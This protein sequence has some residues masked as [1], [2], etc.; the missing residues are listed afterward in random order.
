MI[1]MA[2][3]LMA[4]MQQAPVEL[5]IND[6]CGMIADGKPI[7]VG[8]LRISIDQWVRDGREVQIRFTGHVTASCA[9]DIIA[10]LN[11]AHVTRFGFFGNEAASGDHK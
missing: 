6:R 3:A 5:T 7:P 1:L 8:E 10:T 9:N 11:D 2:A 4:A